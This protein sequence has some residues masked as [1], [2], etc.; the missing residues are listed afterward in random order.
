M[1]IQLLSSF[2]SHLH[3]LVRSRSVQEQVETIIGERVP[4]YK[5]LSNA[6]DE[7]GPNHV[8]R[9]LRM[10]ISAVTMLLCICYFCLLACVQVHGIMDLWDRGCVSKTNAR[11][12]PFASLSATD[13]CGS[14][15]PRIVQ[16]AGARQ[17]QAR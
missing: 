13:G 8:H 12:P 16:C 2:T 9:W 17:R 15:L 6:G 14:P 10:L 3:V 1:Y 11:I 7:L 5:L 4:G